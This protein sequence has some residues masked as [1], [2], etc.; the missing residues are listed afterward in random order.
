MQELQN[1]G[2]HPAGFAEYHFF[3][4]DKMDKGI[5]IMEMERF[6][7]V[8]ARA[9]YK[10][11]RISKEFT[12][13][14][15]QQIERYQ[16]VE[17][18]DF[19]TQ[20][21]ERLPNPAG[22]ITKGYHKTDY[23]VTV[24]VAK[25]LALIERTVLGKTVRQQLLQQEKEAE[26]PCAVPEKDGLI[27]FQYEHTP[28]RTVMKGDDPWFVAA[29]V[30]TVLDIKNPRDAIKILDDDERS[31]VEISDGAGGPE[32]NIINE[33]GLY[34]LILRSNKPEAK[35]FRK[36]VTSEVLPSIRKTGMYAAFGEITKLF[37]ELKK[38]LAELKEAQA[39]QKA[40]PVAQDTNADILRFGGKFLEITG[41]DGDYVEA[42][43][44]FKLFF[45]HVMT[46][47][48]NS[49]QFFEEISYVFPEMWLDSSRKHNP[50]F[51]GCTIK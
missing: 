3:K 51:R 41:D 21:T 4:E 6:Q 30:C 16:L 47:P 29:D 38:E 33:S 20:K 48:I 1:N 23:F 37:T 42:R 19:F 12:T 22:A 11:L 15:K 10:A 46:V 2:A 7:V 45:R 49:K 25:T 13:W 39:W 50:V 35:R 32:R 17:G 14:I 27:P 44:L 18:E 31:T 24:D 26:Q 5:A 34:A 43:V 9:L 28:V 8:D 36:W 40:L